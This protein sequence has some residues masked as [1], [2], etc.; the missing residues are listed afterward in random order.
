[1]CEFDGPNPR[2]HTVP[3]ASHTQGEAIRSTSVWMFSTR[4]HRVIH[5]VEPYR[6]ARIH[7]LLKR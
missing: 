1:M 6:D 3:R 7:I 4:V 5:N 2:C